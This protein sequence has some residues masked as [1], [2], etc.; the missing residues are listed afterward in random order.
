[1]IDIVSINSRFPSLFSSLFRL[2]INI[3]ETSLGEIWWE[4]HKA[5]LVDDK[6][7]VIAD[8]HRKLKKEVFIIA[9]MFHN[10]FHFIIL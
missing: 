10:P 2:Q 6:M 5:K 1:M 7:E 4:S 9:I 8:L 3:I